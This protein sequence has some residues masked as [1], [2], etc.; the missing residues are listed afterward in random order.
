[1]PIRILPDELVRHI[2]AGEVVERPASI[3]KELLENSLDAGATRIV[4]ELEDGGLTRLKMTDDGHGIAAA[5][6]PNLLHRHA[7]SKIASFDD[8]HAIGTLGFRGEALYSI[9]AVTRFKLTT[10]HREEEVGVELTRDEERGLETRP[11]VGP[12]GTTIEARELFYNL[13]ARRKFLKG[14]Q[15]EY[16]RVA[17]V[18][19][20]YLLAYPGV[21]FELHHN[22]RKV[23]HAYGTSELDPLL[24]LYGQE[25][26]GQLHPVAWHS[27]GVR[28]QGYLAAPA[29]SRSTRRDQTTFVNGRWVKDQGL[30]LAV[31]RAY[32]PMVPEGRYPVFLVRVEVD[33]SEVDVNVHP[34]KTE[35]RFADSRSVYRAVQQGCETA[36]AE[37]RQ[38]ALTSAPGHADTEPGW[39]LELPPLRMPAAPQARI[40][41]RVPAIE[42]EPA[43]DPDTGEVL[44]PLEEWEPLPPEGDADLAPAPNGASTAVAPPLATELPAPPPDLATVP[45]TEGSYVQLPGGTLALNHRGE[46]FLVDLPR[47]QARVLHEELRA[48]DPGVVSSQQLLFPAPLPLDPGLDAALSGHGPELRALGFSW[49]GDPP[50]LVAAPAFLRGGDPVEALLDILEGAAE[51]E[52]AG[53]ADPREALLRS[54]AWRGAVRREHHWKPEELRPLLRALEDHRY[55]TGLHGGPTVLRCDERW[56]GRM[57]GR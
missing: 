5:D 40:A 9:A 13:P 34:H 45:L 19:S 18:V 20:R 15:A 3:A 38:A 28:V 41:F 31:M 49:T 12:A 4:V 52:G 46:L 32:G 57:F 27:A 14:A 36:L 47:L 6:I 29:F 24:A 55:Y 25:L 1:M 33:P 53:L 8:L 54:A 50:S 16:A 21:A 2:A 10:R 51:E 39:D 17:E 7:T 43:I 37:V 56:L 23:L 42:W 35:V 44:S 22:G 26:A 11:W 48:R 30:T